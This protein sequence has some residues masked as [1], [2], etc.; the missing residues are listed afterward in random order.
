MSTPEA[1]AVL[2]G[3]RERLRR[4]A[5]EHVAPIEDFDPVPAMRAEAARLW[6]V[7][8]DEVRVTYDPETKVVHAVF[9][10]KGH[11]LVSIDKWEP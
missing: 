2:E 8:E 1:Q 7:G 11:I 6:G 9:L 5:E 10:P 3:M 4:L